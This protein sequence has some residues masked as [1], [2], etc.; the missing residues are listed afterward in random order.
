[1]RGS[2]PARMPL[3]LVPALSRVSSAAED[4]I[5][6]RRAMTTIRRRESHA[7]HPAR[8]RAQAV[9]RTT[10]IS[11]RGT[12]RGSRC[13]RLVPFP[14]A[15]LSGA[16]CCRP[17]VLVSFT[18]LLVTGSFAGELAYRHMIGVTGHDGAHDGTHEH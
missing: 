5:D 3:W 16:L 10:G 11:S 14:I 9:A 13:T 6:L 18:M 1:M 17:R 15:F 8:A 2:R 12:I 4:G 7:H